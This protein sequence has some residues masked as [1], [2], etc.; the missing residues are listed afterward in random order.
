MAWQKVAFSHPSQAKKKEKEKLW[1]D[2]IAN[3]V[4]LVVS[5]L[6]IGVSCYV[7][8]VMMVVLWERGRN[9]QSFVLRAAPAL[10][11]SPSAKVLWAIDA[12]A[13]KKETVDKSA[14]V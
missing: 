13:G 8:T 4:L 10:A 6:D 3:V 9:L 14:R 5:L 12:I 2:W 1:L 11:L 7:M